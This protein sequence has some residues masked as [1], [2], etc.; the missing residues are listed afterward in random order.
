MPNKTKEPIKYVTIS[1][2]PY[3][4]E[5]IKKIAKKQRRTIKDTIEILIETNY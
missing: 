1:I 2:S 4:L 5:L 3:H